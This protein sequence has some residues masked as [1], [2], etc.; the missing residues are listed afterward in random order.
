MDIEQL[1]KCPR[2]QF[3][4]EHY[5]V[6]N[7]QWDF[8]FDYD[9]KG[10][11][12]QFHKGFKK[13]NDILVPF[14]YETKASGVGIEEL[15][16]NVWYQKHL[17]ITKKARKRY[18]L[19]FEGLDYVSKVFVNSNY[20]GS[21]R[22]A[23]HRQS[24]DITDYIKDGDN[25]LVVKCEDSYSMRQPRGKQRWKKESF[26]CFYVDIV[27]IYKPVWLE[28]VDE[29]YIVHMKMTPDLDRNLIDFD[30]EY[31]RYKDLKLEISLVDNGNIIEEK[32]YPLQSKYENHVFEIED[33]MTPWS[34]LNP[35]LY[36]LKLRLI[37]EK[38]NI[39]DEVISYVGFRKVEGKDG[40]TYLNNRPL[41]QKLV[42]DQG[43]WKE[44]SI[45]PK[46]LDDLKDDILKMKAFGFNGCRKHEKVEDERFL[47]L[48]DY[49]GY[50]VWEEIP[51]FYE[52]SEEA[53]ENYRGE[54]PHILKEFYN[55]PS[56]ITWTLF[57]ESWGIEDILDN[58]DTQKFVD[59]MYH[60][61][62]E[63]DQTRFVITNDG[64]EHTLSD[65]ITYHH[66]NQSGD[67][68]Y[69]FYEDKE[70]SLTEIWKD[71]WKGAFAHGYQYRGQPIIFSEFGGTAFV[72][73]VNDTN[74]GY[75]QAVKDDDEYIARLDSLFGALQK[76]SY[77]SG[78][79]YTQVSDVE[80]EVNGLLD[81]DHKEKINPELLRKIQERK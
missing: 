60:L 78:Y 70:A 43:Y 76:L 23:Y 65:I 58:K 61:T 24:F 29:S 5:E 73:N 67:L 44:S 31:S 28:E 80:Q 4:R 53:K 45:T 74:W 9:N 36:D 42:L 6:L 41:Y 63:Y 18:I 7:G 72:K 57:N 54:L 34:P 21:D 49:L 64:W 26:T 10:E 19:H 13:D 32:I 52:M 51:S 12:L 20:V 47:L 50:L 16:E 79:C 14:P 48:A 62:K 38:N 35:K 3:V 37:D 81:H 77:L 25:L 1:L 56:I 66:Y 68:L 33:K 59:E 2:C 69:S 40:F 71:H 75:G 17:N 30:F 46:S 27:G 15:C 55:H 39:L 11:A 8:A 22:G